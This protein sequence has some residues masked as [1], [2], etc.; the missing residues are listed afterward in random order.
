[1]VTI[2]MGG[3]I[4]A[5]FIQHPECRMSNKE[6]RMS[7]YE[8][9]HQKNICVLKFKLRKSSIINPCSIFIFIQL[10]LQKL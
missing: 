10:D 6:H 5:F 7:I 8:G 3:V 4:P 9:K 1:M 2:F